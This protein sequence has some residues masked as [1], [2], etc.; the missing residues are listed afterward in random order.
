MKIALDYDDTYTED[1]DLFTAFVAK[2][3][4]R[5]H[6][7][8]FV[9]ARSILGDN[10]DIETSAKLLGIEVVY[11]SHQPK[12]SCWDADIWIDDMPE[13]IVLP[14]KPTGMGRNKR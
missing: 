11:C 1:N 5:N 10:S 13:M 2:A 14:P 9:T 7:I 8:K 12:R 4:S 6:E 3:K